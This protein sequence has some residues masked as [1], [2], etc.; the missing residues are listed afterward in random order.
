[1]TIYRINEGFIPV[2]LTAFTAAAQDNK[3]ILRWTTASEKNNRGFW[4]EK[5]DGDGA[6]RQ[7]FFVE[8]AGTSSEINYY[9]YIDENLKPGYYSYR[10]KQEDFDGRFEYSG[11]RSVEISAPL[12]FELMDNYPNPFNPSTEIK[13]SLPVP[14]EISLIVYDLLGREVVVLYEGICEAGVHTVTFD[15]TELSSGV[16]IYKLTAGKFS[17]VKKMNMIK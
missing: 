9:Q 14:S 2:E 16:F 10:I 12:E 6:F 4:I 5:A 15:G 13:F 8:G 7:L 11:I 3:A 17:G 1:M